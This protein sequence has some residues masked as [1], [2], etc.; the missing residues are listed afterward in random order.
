[1]NLKS[2]ILNIQIVAIQT[3]LRKEMVR[4]FRIWPQTF[5]P[6]V[7]TTTLYFL[8]FGKFI[9]SQIAP[10]SGYSYM[11]YIVPGLVMMAV[12]TAAYTSTVFSYFG[13]KFMKNLEEVLVAPVSY[14]SIIFGY[15]L[16]GVVRALI[17]GVIILGV[18][19]FFVSMSMAHIW[20]I[21]FFMISTSIMFA[22]AGLVNAIYAK[23]F[24][25]TS[26]VTTFVLTPLTYLG[27][28]FYSIYMLPIFWQNVSM[29]NPIFY[30]ING[31]RYGFLGI[32]D[33]SIIKSVIV[34]TTFSLVFFFWCIYLFKTKRAVRV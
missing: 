31:F 3:M 20:A 33:V 11:S 16:G 34:T 6:P 1:M 10:V 23:S 5:L 13:A 24:D 30:I 15:V 2:K 12:I 22:L 9:G 27:G 28:V 19:M 14:S 4:I 21:L 32:T 8:V 7:I 17:T 25:D 18:S 29:F 26:I